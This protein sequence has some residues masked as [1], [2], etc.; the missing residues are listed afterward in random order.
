MKTAGRTRAAK[1]EDAFDEIEWCYEQGWTDGLPVVPPTPE[2][3]ERMLAA[4]AHGRDE[5]I[6]VLDPAHGIATVEKI[7]VNSV[8]AGCKPEYFPAV[9]AAVQAITDPQFS[10]HAV[11]TAVHQSS[12]LLIINGPA[13]NE[14]DVNCGAN[15]FG[16]GWRANATIGRA[17]RLVM[18]N[19]GGAIPGELDAATLGH[20]GKYSY[21]IGENEEANPWEPLHVERGYPADASTI[22]AFAAE[23]PEFVA[24]LVSSTA[25]GVLTTIADCMATMGN[26]NAYF[27]GEIFLVLC[28]EH[29]RIIA[30]DGWS[31]QDVRLFLHDQARKPVGKLKQG[32]AYRF[33]GLMDWPKWVDESDDEAMVPIPHRP[34]DI[35]IVVAGGHTGATSAIIS[36]LGFNDRKSPTRYITPDISCAIGP[37]GSVV[38][39]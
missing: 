35:S 9:L 29:A 12:P 6:A 26:Y 1:A 10:L 4:T 39:T 27:G 15:V 3:L 30:R 8:M 11:Q 28:P 17:L 19:V 7:A 16:Q 21:C 23:G 14:L 31:K 38:C 13:R 2:R 20:P 24:D 32:G 37:D 36:G 22:T 5:V 25:R 33:G 34:E 18:V